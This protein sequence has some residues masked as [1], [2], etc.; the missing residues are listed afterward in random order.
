MPDDADRNVSEQAAADAL[1]PVDEEVA[2]NYEH[3]AEVG[4][5]V[6]GEGQ[7]G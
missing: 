7:I 1:A 4:A 2:E 5:N 6:E 3:Q